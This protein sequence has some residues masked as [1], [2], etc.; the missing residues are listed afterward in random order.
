MM[1]WVGSIFCGCAAVWGVTRG[2]TT[3][4]AGA[5]EPR[6][7]RFEYEEPH[8]G[9]RFKLTFYAADQAVANSAA[10]KAFARIAALNQALTDYDD[11]SELMQLCQRGG[12]QPGV[13]LP[14]SPELFRVLASAQ[15]L[16]ADSDGAF[17]V[18]VGPLVG[19]WRTARKTRTLPPEDQLAAARAVVG[20]KL[21]TLSE[22]ERTVSLGRAGMR[23]DLGG[24]AKGYAADEALAELAK[25]G[26]TRALVAAAG[27]ITTSDAPPDAAGWRVGV[28]PLDPREPPSEKLTLA[29]RAVSTSGDAFQF[30]EIAGVRYSHLVDPKTGLGLTGR[31]S[32]TITAPTGIVADALASAVCV[33]GPERGL[34][35]VE[36]KPETAAFIVRM[37]D[38]GKVETLRSKRWGELG[39]R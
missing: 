27:D 26:V 39:N 14:V 25:A 31:M 12:R 20:Y 28:A 19:L 9:T 35:L 1:R 33:L 21:L 32:V 3:L 18:T 13:A 24:I 37:N 17:D 4:T 8:M 23:L 34:A 2:D 15:Q 16:S 10:K 6:L 22:K 7:E 5:A 11:Q 36:S 38:E 29:R 30:V